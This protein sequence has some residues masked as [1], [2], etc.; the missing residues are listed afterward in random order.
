VAEVEK[1]PKVSLN[2][3]EVMATRWVR[4]GDLVQEVVKEPSRFTPWLR[5]YLDTYAPQIFG[6]L[7]VSCVN[8]A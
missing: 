1:A 5:I 6:K 3:D 4:Y 7:A 8:P 2:P